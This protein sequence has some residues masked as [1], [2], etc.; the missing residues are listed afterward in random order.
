MAFKKAYA[1]SESVSDCYRMKPRGKKVGDERWTEAMNQVLNAAAEELGFSIKR[2]RGRVDFRWYRKDESIAVEHENNYKGI[3]REELPKLLDVK[4]D[5]R[6]MTTY[7]S[8][9]EFRGSD[10]E[11]L[12]EQVHESVCEHLRTH[13]ETEFLLLLNRYG[14]NAWARDPKDEPWICY[15]WRRELVRKKILVI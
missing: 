2:E 8:T 6:V 10:G 12:A 7:V 4:A 1:G 13:D 15:L 9:N 5:L 11:N 3:F 14:G